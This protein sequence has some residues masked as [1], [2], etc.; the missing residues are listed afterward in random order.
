MP[1]TDINLIFGRPKSDST[2]IVHPS[3]VHAFKLWQ[4]FISNV[5]PL[6]KLLHG[7]SVQKDLLQVL[8]EPPST[9][10]PSECLIY[11]IY[12]VA[13]VSLTDKECSNMFD[14]SRKDLLA[15]YCNLTEVALSRVDFLR[16]TDLRVLQAFTLYLVDYLS[17]PRSSIHPILISSS[18]L[19][20]TSAIMTSCGYSLALRRA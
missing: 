12:L 17:I 15:R 20:A 14:E 4:V 2:P 16:S 1:A 11:S 18:F 19:S 8:S 7:P 6:T 9:P 10:S 13:V 5:H 3:A